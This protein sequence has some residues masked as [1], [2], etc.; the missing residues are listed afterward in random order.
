MVEVV[1][2]STSESESSHNALVKATIAFEKSAVAFEKAVERGK[3]LAGIG[4]GKVPLLL[5]SSYDVAA[6]I[7]LRVCNIVIT[8][9]LHVQFSRY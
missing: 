7:K 9:I 6:A 3:S 4:S 1:S 8:L 2:R 5:L